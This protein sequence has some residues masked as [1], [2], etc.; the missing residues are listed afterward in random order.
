MEKLSG[1][2]GVLYETY[3]K[4]N[5]IRKSEREFRIKFPCVQVPNMNTMHEVR[6]TGILTKC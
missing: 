1:P 4:W 5:C 2:L 6:A 3:V